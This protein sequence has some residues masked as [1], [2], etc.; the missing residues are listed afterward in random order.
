MFGDLLGQGLG[1]FRDSPRIQELLI[2]RV[3]VFW[4]IVIDPIQ[5]QNALGRH[6]PAKSAELR[7]ELGLYQ[8]CGALFDALSRLVQ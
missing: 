8:T 4:D 7:G 6:V 1:R 5:L 2:R 3:F